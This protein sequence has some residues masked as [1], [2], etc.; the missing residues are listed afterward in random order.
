MRC[1]TAVSTQRGF[2][3]QTVSLGQL[4]LVPHTFVTERRDTPAASLFASPTVPTF[5]HRPSVRHTIPDP[6]S[7]SMMQ[8]VGSHQPN[9]PLA[10]PTL[11]GGQFSGGV[12]F[13]ARAGAGARRSARRDAS[14]NAI[15]AT[16]KR[17]RAQVS[18]RRC[19][20]RTRPMRGRCMP[21]ACTIQVGQAARVLC[22]QPQPIACAAAASRASSCRSLLRADRAAARASFAAHRTVRACR[23]TLR[24][25]SASSPPSSTLDTGT[26]KLF[27]TAVTISRSRRSISPSMSPLA[28]SSRGIIPH[29]ASSAHRRSTSPRRAR[30]G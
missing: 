11:P 18:M 14:T 12:A 2:S 23:R 8:T 19:Y 26:P 25:R 10:L 29:E 24:R 28:R 1:A 15:G 7:V 20:A 22:D 9:A 4:L 6:Q 3:E 5:M 27:T 21:D 30:S 17:R 16:A 13:S